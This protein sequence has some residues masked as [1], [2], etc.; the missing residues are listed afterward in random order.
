MKKIEATFENGV[1]LNVITGILEALIMCD[2][3]VCFYEEKQSASESAELAATDSQQIK[4]KMP[5][6]QEFVNWAL[7]KVD[8]YRTFEEYYNYFV[9]HF[10]H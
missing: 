5:S 8:G 3:K 9:Q 7:G 6:F 1:S 4:P 10:G 2:A